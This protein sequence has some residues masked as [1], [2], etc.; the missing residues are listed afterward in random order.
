MQKLSLSRAAL[1]VV[2]LALVANVL[3]SGASNASWARRSNATTATREPLSVAAPIFINGGGIRLTTS[4]L[5]AVMR[6]PGNNAAMGAQLALRASESLPH[7]PRPLS[8]T[9]VMFLQAEVSGSRVV[10]FGDEAVETGLRSVLLR[11]GVDYSVY[12]FANNRPVGFPYDVGPPD[13]GMLA[14]L[15]PLDDLSLTPGIPMIV[16]IVANAR[17]TGA[18]DFDWPLVDRSSAPGAPLMDE[19]PSFVAHQYLTSVPSR[20]VLDHMSPRSPLHH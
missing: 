9:Q 11:D 14:F 19:G 2:A 10:S 3:F 18:P 1:L 12:L 16:E 6:Y 4:G 7:A 17:K 15:W 13:R 5:V 8:G 20:G